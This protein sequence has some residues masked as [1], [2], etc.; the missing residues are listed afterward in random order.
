MILSNSQLVDLTGY[1][2]PGRQVEW[3]TKRGWVFEHPSRRGQRPK[4]D[5]TYYEARMSG[6]T[7]GRRRIEPDV[8][9]MLR[10]RS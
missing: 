7:P 1:Q 6:Q 9:V 4:V 5:S 3:L 10:G 8:S 2:Q